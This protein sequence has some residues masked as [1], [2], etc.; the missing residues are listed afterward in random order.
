MGVPTLTICRRLAPRTNYL[1]KILQQGIESDHFRLKKDM[2]R[3]GAFQSFNTAR[4]SIQGYP[5]TTGSSTGATPRA[6]SGSSR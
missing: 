1:T 5:D 3:V 6:D 2:P 4:R